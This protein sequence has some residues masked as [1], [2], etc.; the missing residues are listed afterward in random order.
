MPQTMGEPN[1]TDVLPPRSRTP[2]RG[3]GDVSVERSL[4]EVREAH[5]K[6]LAMAATLEVKIEWLS[7][8]LIRSQLEA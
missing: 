6:T 1:L 7:C 8:P 3:R 5:Q 2:R 4:A